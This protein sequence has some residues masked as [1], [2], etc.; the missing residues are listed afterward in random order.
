[1][2]KANITLEII[3]SCLIRANAIFGLVIIFMN[4][5][6]FSHAFQSPF[7]SLALDAG[8]SSRYFL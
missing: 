1:M 7:M 3:N 6:L 2:A 5:P 4:K 8:F